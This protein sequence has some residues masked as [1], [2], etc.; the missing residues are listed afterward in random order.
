MRAGAMPNGGPLRYCHAPMRTESLPSAPRRRRPAPLAAALL[1]A[2]TLL[3]PAA[4]AAAPATDG[5]PAESYDV[6]DDPLFDDEA[7][8]DA[9]L[10]G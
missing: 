2:L 7:A 9:A 4:Q 8:P 6:G 1:A 5:A 10:D 3:P